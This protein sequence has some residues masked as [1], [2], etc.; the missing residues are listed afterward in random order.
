MTPSSAP[1]AAIHDHHDNDDDALQGQDGRA[2]TVSDEHI[3]E[4]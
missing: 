2:K 4:V 3:I 1:T